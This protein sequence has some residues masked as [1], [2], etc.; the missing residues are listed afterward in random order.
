MNGRLQ[1]ENQN[2]ERIEISSNIKQSFW[3]VV[4]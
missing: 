1:G 3:S 2:E 4:Y